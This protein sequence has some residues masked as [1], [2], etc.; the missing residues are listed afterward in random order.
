MGTIAE[1]DTYTAAL[2]GA[3]TAQEACD[4]LSA[5]GFAASVAGDSV[6]VDDGE[7]TAEPFE[8]VNKIGDA[9]YLWCLRDSGGEL[10]RCVARGP[11]GSC[12]PRH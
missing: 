6:T 7:I 4:R 1:I 9:F 5:A 3:Q 11:Q 8:G 2:A 10:A 12:P